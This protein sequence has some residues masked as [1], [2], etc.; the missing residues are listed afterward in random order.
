MLGRNSSF[1][2]LWEENCRKKEELRWGRGGPSGLSADADC[3]SPDT[4]RH[5]GQQDFH[6]S[7]LLINPQSLELKAP[8]QYG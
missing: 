2:H 3:L 1:V 6:L 7:G 5:P 8:N 4:R